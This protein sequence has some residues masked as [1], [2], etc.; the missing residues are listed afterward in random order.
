MTATIRS[1]PGAMAPG[2]LL[3][4]AIRERRLVTFTLH[5]L[6]RRAEPHDYGIAGGHPTLFFYQVGGQSR[7]LLPVGWR[8][9][10]LSDVSDLLLLDI[11]FPGPRDSDSSRHLTWDRLLASVS[12][13]VEEDRSDDV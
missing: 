9:A 1:F 12:R 8:W 11:R 13:E 4:I 3:Q 10:K 7:A 2:D 6:E 5:G